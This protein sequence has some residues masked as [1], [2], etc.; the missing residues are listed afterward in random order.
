MCL[1]RGE[2]VTVILHVRTSMAPIWTT[3]VPC[4][5]CAKTFKTRSAALNHMNQPNSRCRTQYSQ[6]FAGPSTAMTGT[7]NMSSADSTTAEQPDPPPETQ[8]P[9]DDELDMFDV[10]DDSDMPLL[11][12]QTEDNTADVDIWSDL[13]SIQMDVDPDNINAQPEPFYVEYYPGAA[14]TTGKGPTFMELFDV[15]QF[16]TKRTKNLYYPF[17]SSGEWEVATF[18]VKSSLSMR[19]IDKFLKLQLVSIFRFAKSL[20][21]FLPLQVKGVH[22]SFAT[23]KDL[24]SRIEILPPG[25]KWMCKPIETPIP[26][27]SRVDLFYRD[28]VECLQALMQNPLLKDHISFSPFQLYE[29]AAKVTRTYTEWLSGNMA[30]YMQVSM[31][32]IILHS[33]C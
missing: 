23:A 25:P 14:C 28:P 9:D 27:K 15:D 8:D 11:E 24:Y 29:S 32:R 6:N 16:A 13:E 17:A 33:N 7:A 4:P 10:P 19:A 18:L 26:T 21:H 12:Q 5:W 3:D 2:H 30:W 31:E 1:R 20:S 22:L